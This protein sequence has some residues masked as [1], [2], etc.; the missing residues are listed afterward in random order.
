MRDLFDILNEVDY[1]RIR[2]RDEDDTVPTGEVD[3]TIEMDITELTELDVEV[4]DDD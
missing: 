2:Y 3:D 1:S 4:S